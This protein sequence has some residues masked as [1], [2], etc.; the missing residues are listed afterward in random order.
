MGYMMWRVLGIILCNHDPKVKVK[1]ELEMMFMKHYA[2][3][4]LLVKKGS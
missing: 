4:P 3:S 1:S 2:P